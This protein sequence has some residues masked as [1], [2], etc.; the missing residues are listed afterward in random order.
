MAG[1]IASFFPCFPSHYTRA[2][3]SNRQFQPDTENSVDA[4]CTQRTYYT[5]NMLSGLYATE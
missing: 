4:L 5:C 1:H 2:H 3:N